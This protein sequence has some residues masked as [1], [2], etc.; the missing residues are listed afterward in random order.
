MAANILLQGAFPW[1]GRDQEEQAEAWYNQP[2]RVKNRNLEDENMRLKRLLREHGI[3]WSPSVAANPNFQAGITNTGKGT[4]GSTR[5]TRASITADQGRLPHLPVEVLLRILHYS[6]TSRDAIIDPLSKSKAENLTPY[7]KS[8]GNQVAIH[9]LATCKAF[10]IEGTRI[11]WENNSFVFTTPEALRNFAEVDAGLRKTVKHV[12]LRII[13]RYFDDEKRP[14]KLGREYHTTLKKDVALKVTPRIKE[15]QTLARKGFH[16]YTWTQTI[17]FLEALRAPF[18]PK[19]DK[20]TSRPR[21]FPNLESMRIDFVNFPEYFLPYSET[22]LHEV[23]SHD[24]G[25]TLNELLVTG[26]PCCEVGMKAGADLQGMV[27]DDGLFLD[28]NPAFIQLK[29]SLKPLSGYGLCAKVVRAYRKLAKEKMEKD[30]ENAQ[31]GQAS[32]FDPTQ[33][34]A[35]LS[36]N[37]GHSHH[38]HLPD[39]PSVPE[40]EG[41][42]VS[43]WKKK[44][45]VW[46]RVP[47]SRDSNVRKWIEFDRNSGYPIEDVLDFYDDDSD[48][49]DA[50]LC[51][52]CGEVHSPFDPDDW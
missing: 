24:L 50:F 32:D 48:D 21:L 22:D 51:P 11:F 1:D 27:K 43:V 9:F 52:K 30:K 6:L 25:C 5:R 33:T 38:A 35:N 19:H 23:S 20:K 17:D 15:N 49:E 31:N 47:E 42:P 29:T 16:C 37:P 12:N 28:G 18:D 10:H 7:E 39:L 8:R 26:L 34:F 41:H 4:S 46:K 40:E 36:M 2:L 3:A 45:T 44:K 13:A 14:H